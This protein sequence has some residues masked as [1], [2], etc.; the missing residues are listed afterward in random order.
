M[1]EKPRSPKQQAHARTIADR[2]YRQAAEKIVINPPR[3]DQPPR[4]S[5]WTQCPNREGFSAKARAESTRMQ[6]SKFG[7]VID[8]TYRSER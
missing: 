7:H 4:E 3:D 1:I 8:P 2:A 6:A 5:W